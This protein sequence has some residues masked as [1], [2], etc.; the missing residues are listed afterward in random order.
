LLVVRQFLASTNTTVIPHPPYSP[1]LTPC[2]SS[3]YIRRWNWSLRGDVFDNIK[4]IQT[5]SRK[6][7]KML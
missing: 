5:E 1:D 7:M 3:S 4:K 2:N 6:V